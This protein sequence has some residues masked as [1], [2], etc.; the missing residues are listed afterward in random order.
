MPYPAGDFFVR[1]CAPRFARSYFSGEKAPEHGET[2]FQL[3]RKKKLPETGSKVGCPSPFLAG[4]KKSQ[5]KTKNQETPCDAQGQRITPEEV[6]EHKWR[7]WRGFGGWDAGWA[8]EALRG[9]SFK[10][11]DRFRKGGGL[12]VSL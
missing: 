8:A 3:T 10:I 9:V 2:M 6:P 5:K 11:G 7:S 1:E 12:L 4:R